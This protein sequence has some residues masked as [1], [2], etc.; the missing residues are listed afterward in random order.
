[1]ADFIS[2]ISLAPPLDRADVP[3]L[4]R[5]ACLDL[6]R[7]EWLRG[8]LATDGAKMLCWYRAPDAESVRLVERQQGFASAPVW[9][10]DVSAATG[11]GSRPG[12]RERVVVEFEIEGPCGADAVAAARVAA[13]AALEAA[14]LSTSHG[15][16]SGHARRLL[17]LVRSRAARAVS[18]CLRRAG[19]APTALWRCVELD[20]A[21]S[22]LFRAG[23]TARATYHATP[24]GRRTGAQEPRISTDQSVRPG[25]TPAFDAVIIGAGLSGICA[26]ERLVRMGLRVR[27]Y[28]CGSD[29]G[30]VWY[31]NRY[32]G[33]R[34]DSES[35]TYGFSFSES[36]LREWEW[37][38]LFAAQPEISGYLRFVV[39]RLDLR[40]HMSF[41]TRVTTAAYDERS[42][43]WSVETD[44]GERVSARYLVAAA[45]TLSTVQMPD[46][47][48][49]DA[50]LGESYHTAR[51][52][53]QG[54]ALAGKRV[55][56]VGTGASGVQVIQTIAPEV[57]H[58]AVFQRTPTYCIPQR[59]RRLT[60]DDRRQIRLEWDAIL[61]TCRESYGGFV[62]TFDARPGLGLPA[63]LR[64][65]KFESLWQKPGFAFWFGNFGDLMMNPEVNAHAC[66][67][68]RRKIRARV[69]DPEVA[70]RLLP[71]HPFGTK[72]VPLEN[73]Y[74][75][76]YNRP[77]VRLVDL[78]ETPILRITKAG[79]LTSREEHPLDVIVYATGFDAGTGTL[80][81]I[82]IRGRHRRSLAQKWC[83]GPK[84]YLGML[85]SGFPN[86]F[87]VNGPH[88]AAA[89]CNAG[90]CIE[91]NVDWIARCIER[92][93][94]Q[95]LTRA[96]PTVAAEAEWTRHVYETADASL[97]ARMTNSWFFGANT[98]G[99]PRR[100]T[101]YAAG[102]RE[103]RE[104]C[105]AAARAGYP[106]LRMS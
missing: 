57:G 53:A 88:N 1:M 90:R 17:C 81:R 32:P 89:L 35:F 18:A 51:W 31:W 78:R 102:A 64:E 46:Y 80:T 48:G 34:V 75:E 6:Y 84:T 25:R 23:A 91:Q 66:D 44:V 30:G 104:H 60:D 105:E 87:I 86:L 37:R 67:F 10:V 33:A 52:P 54:V 20:P 96:A 103:Y 83:A 70:R 68:V 100:A 13:I 77:N 28:E 41:G 36:L 5:L 22:P 99:K 106:G 94:E 63:E 2:L 65:A 50:F 24:R 14:G 101:I 98:P 19:L 74:Y 85:V 3:R 42:A 73:G 58:L 71:D 27:L 59:N 9:P 69:H 7:V 49:M 15:F 82:D 16:A 79:V 26:L 92:M 38:E 95:G 93:R 12:S 45:G 40:R 62:H 4:A 56:V 29:V 8:Y 21:P 39:D 97:L 55:G 72:R 11:N 76:V 43:C 61:A 47:P